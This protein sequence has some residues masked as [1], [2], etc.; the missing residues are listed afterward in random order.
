MMINSKIV[1]HRILLGMAAGWVGHG[2][3][4]SMP[5]PRPMCPRPTH[6]RKVYRV[7]SHARAHARR[8]QACPTG[9]QLVH[10]G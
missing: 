6:A 7:K 9:A 8:A 3:S 10:Q 1:D 4:D 5:D 2:Q